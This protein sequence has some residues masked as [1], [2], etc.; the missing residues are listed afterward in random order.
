MSLFD[1]TDK[2]FEPFYDEDIVVELKGGEL[3]TVKACVTTDGTLDPMSDEMMDTQEQG[4]SLTF[5]RDDWP[6]LANIKRG[7]KI[8]RTMWN[9]QMKRYSVS[10]VKEDFALGW[11][12]IA[13]EV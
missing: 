13:K 8:T 11:I 10:D 3:V 6:A 7:D 12:C 4:I 9:G 2:A 1:N 5:K